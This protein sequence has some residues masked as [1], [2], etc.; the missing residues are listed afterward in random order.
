[1]KADEGESI[2]VLGNT[3]YFFSS[4]G[5]KVESG[6]EVTVR[7]DT[8]ARENKRVSLEGRRGVYGLDR[9]QHL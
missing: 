4:C 7:I 6:E 5:L 3:L 1:M 2:W 9:S 8:T